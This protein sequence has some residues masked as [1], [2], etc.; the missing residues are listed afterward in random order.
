MFFFLIGIFTGA[1]GTMIGAGGGFILVPLLMALTPSASPAEI[2]AISLLGVAANATSGSFTYLA[3]RRVILWAVVLFSLA[4]VPGSLVG[5]Q[6]TR[7]IDLSGFQKIFAAILAVIGIY[8]AVFA[9]E[10][11]KAGAS[12]HAFKL[13][14]KQLAWGSL[15]SFF[16]GIL[17][18][19]LGIGGG[20]IHVPL[21]SQVLAIPVG[22]AIGTS[23]CILAISAVTASV[24]HWYRGDL[25]FQ[26]PTVLPIAI[27][28]VLG[29]QIGAQLSHRIHGRW[30]LR[31]L[32]GVLILVAIKIFL[33]ALK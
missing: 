27:G 21:L 32:G 14:S 1:L 20:I 23:H 16:V 33:F 10:K 2:T 25:D 18:S 15:L 28:M 24:D 6:L 12:P 5:A 4:A 7:D 11:A 22:L 17:A 30:I 29:A 3:Q 9:K 19:F 8:L 13:S 31:I 26:N